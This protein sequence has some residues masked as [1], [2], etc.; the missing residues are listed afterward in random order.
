MIGNEQCL[1]TFASRF[2]DVSDGSRISCALDEI[3]G[4]ATFRNIHRFAHAFAANITTAELK[5]KFFFGSNDNIRV[6][7][8]YCSLSNCDIDRES[9][10]LDESDLRHF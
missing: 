2:A 7:W 8:D 1:R 5:E 4:M 6:V 10:E 9:E 3:R